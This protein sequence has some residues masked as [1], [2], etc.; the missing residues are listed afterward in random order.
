VAIVNLSEADTQ[1]SGLVDRA[2]A[3]EEIVIARAGKPVATIRAVEES[4]IDR[5]FGALKGKL[6]FSNDFDEGTSA[7]LVELFYRVD[8]D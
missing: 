6:S 8:A 5:G 3:G 4:Q 7:E 1:L 2:A